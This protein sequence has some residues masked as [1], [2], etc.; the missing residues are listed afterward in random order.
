MLVLDAV[1]LIAISTL[2]FYWL[3]LRWHTTCRRCPVIKFNIFFGTEGGTAKRYAYRL[4]NVLSQA[5]RVDVSVTDLINFHKDLLYDGELGI[6][7]F[8]VATY[9]DGEP[10]ANVI[11]FSKWLNT[12]R[13]PL[14][15]LNYSV[16]GLGDSGYLQFNEF[17][18]QIDRRLAFLGGTRKM[19]LCLGDAARNLEADFRTWQISL[20]QL[21]NLTECNVD[22][23]INTSEELSFTYLSSTEV[24]KL[25]GSFTGEPEYRLSFRYNAPTAFTHYLDLT[26]P[27][28]FDVLECL[29]QCAKSKGERVFLQNLIT[30]QARDTGEE[31]YEKW[32]LAAKRNI[33]EVLEDLPSCRPS[34]DLLC[35]LLPRLQP[36]FYSVASSFRCQPDRVRLIVK[37]LEYTSLTGTRQSSY[38]N[39]FLIRFLI[40]TAFVTIEA[41][42]CLV[43]RLHKGVASN[44]LYSMHPGDRVAIFLRS[45]DFRLPRNP[46]TPI[47]MVAAG[48]GIAPFLGFIQERMFI[49]SKGGRLGEAMLFYGCRSPNQDRILPDELAN[50]LNSGVLSCLQF[51]YSREQ[52]QK[53]YVQHLLR[54]CAETIW[55]LLKAKNGHFYVCGDSRGMAQDVRHALLEIIQKQGSLTSTK[56]EEF[57]NELKSARRCIFDTWT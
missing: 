2:V 15:N 39:V 51:A 48:T 29:A 35:R 54:G 14:P 33:V 23:P 7:I 19:P 3:L 34:A 41:H 44:F 47:V 5:S 11:G 27:P 53:V 37:V 17:A 10:P 4:E 31:T 18:K 38:L 8:I 6:N 42:I 45:S 22:V 13:E 50:A 25:G 55:P 12:L 24:E 9:G 43:G 26:T 32:I 16:F 40:E 30:A 56:A 20:C 49:K 52:A 57:F 46:L 28:L 21:Y 1:F 36:R